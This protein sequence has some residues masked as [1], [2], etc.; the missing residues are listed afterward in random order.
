MREKL[1]DIVEAYA[2][3]LDWDTKEEM[4]DSI[5]EFLA[6][7]NNVGHT[8]YALYNRGKYRGINGK[9]RTSNS[10][11][12]TNKHLA[13][14]RFRGHPIEIREKKCTK[15]DA[16]LLGRLVF[17]TREEAEQALLEPPKGE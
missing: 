15:Q 14:T 7:D 13:Y 11:I 12:T 8:V 3:F 1:I 2:D 16:I 17:K 9:T 4:V 5:L 10:Q 6:T